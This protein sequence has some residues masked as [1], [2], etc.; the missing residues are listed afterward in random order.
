M[1]IDSENKR[2]SAQR[3]IRGPRTMPRPDGG[4]D[5]YDRRHRTAYRGP[6][7]ALAVIASLAPAGVTILCLIGDQNGRVLARLRPNVQRASWRFNAVGQMAFALARTDEKLQEEY[8][9]FGNRV[10]LQFDNGLPPWGGIIGSPYEWNEAEVLFQAYSGEEL[11]YRR[12]TARQRRFD[13]A[14]VGAIA[15]ALL[16][17]ADAVYPTGVRPGAIWGGGSGH[18]PEYHYK[19]LGDALRDSLVENLS[20]ESFDVSAREEAGYIVFELNLYGTRGEQKPNV[21]LVENQNVS[22]VRFRVEDNIVNAWY[23]A[24]EGSDWGED[25]RVYAE[26]ADEESIRRYGRREDFEVRSGV[27]FQSTLDETI[28]KRLDETAAPSR[29]LGLAVT[30]DRPGRFGEYDVGDAVMCVLPSYDWQGIRGLYRVLGREF[31]PANG[32]TDLVLEE[33]R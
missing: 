20:A 30:D 5:E 3:L 18:F 16:A 11:L 23:M 9:R 25:D 17:E 12:R 21:A 7:V 27:I 4:A 8:L 13:N 15:L 26:A 33:V 2:R 24:G 6:L 29:V 31:I 14:T 22:D 10:L 32:V 28:A 1:G 19:S